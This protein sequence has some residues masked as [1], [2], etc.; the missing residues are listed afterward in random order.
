MVARMTGR[1]TLAAMTLRVGVA[2]SA[3]FLAAGLVLQGIHP[4]PVGTVSPEHLRAAIEGAGRLNPGS[5][6]HIGLLILLLTPIARIAAVAFEFMRIRERTFVLIC[7]GV[8][9]LLSIS[10]VIGLR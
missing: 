2:L 5:L 10:V 7:I 4:Q 1:F 8:L 3:L 6:V 9:F